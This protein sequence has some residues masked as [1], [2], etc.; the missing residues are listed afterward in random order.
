MELLTEIAPT[1][2]AIKAKQVFHNLSPAEL[3][4]AA[5][6]NGEGVLTDTGALMCDTG[7][8]TGRSPKDKFLVCDEKTES[9]VWWGDVNFKFS[10]EK[11]DALLNK[12]LVF[13]EDK[14]IYVRQAVAGAN[15][16]YRLS[17]EIINTQAWHN[18]FCNNMFIRPTGMIWPISQQILPLSVYP[19][20]K[21]NQ[22]LMEPVRLIL[23]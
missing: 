14:R 13:L 4:E 3:I 18:L 19:N 10:P 6:Q 22:P 9:T 21:Q 2:L 8:F 7:K 12:M 16:D 5:L 1:K 11:F 20:L 23:R 15:P 17:L